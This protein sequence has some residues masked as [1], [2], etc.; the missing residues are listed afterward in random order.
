MRR[1][2]N[3]I[4]RIAEAD[5]I[6]AAYLVAS[7]GKRHL[8]SVRAFR[9]SIDGE[10]PQIRD[11]LLSGCVTWGPYHQFRVYDP[12][13]RTICAAPFRDRVVQHAIMAVCDPA[14]E[15]YQIHDSYACRKNRGLDGAFTRTLNYTRH[16][17]WYAKFD[18]R[19]Y[20]ENIDHAIL[21]VMLRRRFKD[22]RLIAV[23][24]ALIDGY[25]PKPGKGIPIGNLTSQY[26]AN[27]YLALWDHFVKETLGVACYVRYMDDFIIWGDDKGTLKAYAEAAVSFL[28]ERL[29]L[30]LKPVCLNAC[31]RGMTFLGYRIYPGRVKLARRSRVRFRSK[32]SEYHD[33]YVNG[34]WSEPETARHVEPLVAFVQRAPTD[35]YP[36][37]VMEGLGLCPR[38]RTA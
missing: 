8:P 11:E 15:T 14:F 19:K 16:N 4:E 34:E 13:E 6:R 24:D 37:R 30:E 33:H 7:R 2:G 20:F 38:A 32:L 31:C 21:K 22:S 1:I 26:F 12:K 3:L 5:N 10:L 28:R 25:C 9:D 29:A 18:V 36:R 27:H 35:G 17:R 23:F